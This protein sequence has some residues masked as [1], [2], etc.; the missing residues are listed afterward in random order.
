MVFPILFIL[1]KWLGSRFDSVSDVTGG[2]LQ[3]PIFVGLGLDWRQTRDCDQY[4]HVLSVNIR[5]DESG[6]LR[7]SG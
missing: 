4:W 5:V 7:K 3:P 1:F 6:M 2:E